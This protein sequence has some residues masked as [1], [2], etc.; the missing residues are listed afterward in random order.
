MEF[1][2]YYVRYCMMQIFPS[3]MCETELMKYLMYLS[4][5]NDNETKDIT[6]ED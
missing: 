6:K 4:E 1:D 5:L 2:K 3:C